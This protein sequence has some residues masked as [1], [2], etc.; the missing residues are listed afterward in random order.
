VTM[1]VAV[2]YRFPEKEFQYEIDRQDTRNA[3]TGISQNRFSWRLGGSKPYSCG[4][5]L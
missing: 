4:R 2:R 5:K 3:W 1:C